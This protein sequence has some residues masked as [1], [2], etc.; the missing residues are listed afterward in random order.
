MGIFGFGSKKTEAA[1]ATATATATAPAAAF[2]LD[3][4]KGQLLDLTKA[5]PGLENVDVGAGWNPAKHGKSFDLDLCAYLYNGAG[6]LVDTVY[7]GD[8]R[9]KGIF[10]NGDNLTGAGAGDDEVISC[11]LKEINGD[12][13]KIVFGVVIYHGS[14]K[15]QGFS[16]VNDAFIRLVDK[17]NNSEICRFNMT[18]SGGDATAVAA[19]ALEKNGDVWSFRGIEEYSNDTVDSLGRKCSNY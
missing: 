13:K 9:A 15:G 8:K 10:L 2:S 3:L 7:F 5:A 18:E 6:A 16:M 1:P 4:T 11:N 19:A 17:R 12:V 14:A